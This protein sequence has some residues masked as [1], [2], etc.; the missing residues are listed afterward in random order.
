MIIYTLSL[1]GSKGEKNHE[2]KTSKIGLEF[3]YHVWDTPD[4]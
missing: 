2:G 3:G 1:E 4:P